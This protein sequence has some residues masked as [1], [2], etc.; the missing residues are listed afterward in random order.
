M[1]HADLRAIVAVA[2]E[3]SFTRAARA[4]YVTQSA[5][6]QRVRRIESELRR[7]LFRRSPSG[8]VTTPDGAHLIAKAEAL[9]RLW[10]ET[11]GQGP[12]QAPD[13]RML[14][15]STFNGNA[16]AVAR[17]L[18]PFLPDWQVEIEYVPNLRHAISRLRE[19]A[20]HACL[21]YG[22]ARG[23]VHDLTDLHV[24][25][26]VLDPTWVSIGASHELACLGEL[27]I[28][29]INL[30]GLLWLVSPS[31]DSAADWEARLLRSTA[32]EAKTAP[33]SPTMAERLIAQN[34]AAALTSAARRPPPHVVTLPLTP[35]AR[36][37][38]YLAW[39][40]A[41]VSTDLADRIRDGL[42]AH[43]RCA[44][45]MHPRYW[46]WICDHPSHFPG[47]AVAR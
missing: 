10:D 31:D 29:Q 28:D 39:E 35:M 6:S 2:R 32:T 12:H 25:T 20:F 16:E 42:R 1:D 5:L 27:T 33:T 43:Y 38:V 7:P 8:V 14:R 37:H 19:G 46:R 40:P 45:Q 47:I 23:L 21:L 9:L 11:F 17:H 22:D 26:V 41:R 13:R 4:L 34:Q 18:S 36:R 15:L 30:A 24:S 44:A 3:L